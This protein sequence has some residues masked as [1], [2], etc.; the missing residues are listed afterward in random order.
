ML[1]ISRYVG[2]R[3]YGV[4][5]T[6]DGSETIV[7]GEEL[8][9][10]CSDL[11]LDIVGVETSQEDGLCYVVNVVPYQ[12]R[13]T[14]SVSQVKLYVLKHVTL[15]TYGSMI[16]HIAWNSSEIDTPV[17]IKLSDFGDILGDCI[18]SGLWHAN[19]HM[20][21]LSLD[22]HISFGANTFSLRDE[23][24]NAYLSISGGGVL[25][26]VTGVTDD[27]VAERVYRSIYGLASGAPFK[28]ILDSDTRKAAMRSKLG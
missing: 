14:L 17:R 22:D 25:V 20:V 4:V 7:D 28:S 2:K 18:L 24:D 16:T 12:L 21:I 5:D 10:I 9:H 27:V 1:Y 8:Y 15:K 26:D 3:G 19:Q 13:S 6:D 11:F 23:D